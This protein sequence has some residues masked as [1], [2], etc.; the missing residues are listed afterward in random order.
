MAKKAIRAAEAAKSGFVIGREKFAKICAVEGIRVSPAM[1]KYF[2]GF[3][4]N[5]LSS[6][7]RRTALNRKYGKGRK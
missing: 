1:E 3:E 4:E 2:R 7:E 6:R 5:G